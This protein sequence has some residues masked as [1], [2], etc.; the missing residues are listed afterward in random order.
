MYLSPTSPL[1]FLAN[2]LRRRYARARA[3]EDLGASAIEWVIITGV[4]VAIAAAIGVIIYQLI[5]REARAIDIPDAP[6]GP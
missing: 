5:E 1:L 6:G 3:S 4:L 2:E